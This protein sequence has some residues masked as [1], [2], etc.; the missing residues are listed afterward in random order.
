MGKESRVYKMVIKRS[1][2]TVEVRLLGKAANSGTYMLG[3]ARGLG[4]GV[5]ELLKQPA[6]SQIL[7]RQS[8][9]STSN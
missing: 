8:R 2:D 7:D 1:G 6:M 9:H 5:E 3:Q 4:I